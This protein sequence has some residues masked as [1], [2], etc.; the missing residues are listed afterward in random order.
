MTTSKPSNLGWPLHAE[1]VS[2]S[3]A[4]C[5]PDTTN[6]PLL[7]DEHP[8]ASLA[9]PRAGCQ[10]T[11]S[12]TSKLGLTRIK[13]GRPVTGGYSGLNPHPLLTQLRSILEPAKQELERVADTGA[14]ESWRVAYLGRSGQLTTLLRGL[15]SLT[16]DERRLV[17]AEAN[18]AKVGLEQR[19]AE[20]HQT[21]QESETSL[22]ITGDTVDV[23][24][25]GRPVTLGR[26]HPIT[27]VVREICAAFVSMGFDIVEGPE[28]EWELY[29]FD[30]LNIPRDHPARDMFDTFWVHLIA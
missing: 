3:R 22:L 17:G 20:R 15:G 30:L 13:L 24:L 4:L 14:L 5:R 7:K 12:L 6:L 21:L 18:Q 1:A 9:M 28:V 2:A 27:Q 26:L 16:P 25:P 19:L 11:H 8:E 10:G 29:N 23:T